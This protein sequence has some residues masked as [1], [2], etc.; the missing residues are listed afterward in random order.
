MLNI[1]PDG[2]VTNTFI[3]GN[4]F[5]QIS[6]IKDP[7]NFGTTTTATAAT[8]KAMKY[9]DFAS[10]ANLSAF[11][12]DDVLTGGTSGA[13]AFVVDI[14]TSN[15]Y[16]Y[17]AQNS[18]TGYTAFSNGETVTGANGGSAALESSSAVGNPEV[19]RDSGKMLFLENRTPINRTATQIEDIKLII[20]F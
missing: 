20:E 12:V 2:T 7:T 8:L 5:R 11:V 19:D 13:K 10:G 1:K 9:L 17:Y 18:K 15:G 14:D 4:D 6:L 3:V 16:I